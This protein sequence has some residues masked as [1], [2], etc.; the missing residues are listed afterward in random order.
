MTTAGSRSP[1][2]TPRR[3]STLE[4]ILDRAVEIMADVGVAGLTMTRLAR[5]LSIQ[6][7]SLY[8]WFP[9]VLAVHDAVFARGQRANL[10]AWRAGLEGRPA[11]LEAVVAGMTATAQWAVTHPVE[12]QLLFW[13]PVPGFRPSAAAMA[14]ADELV[15]E[16]REHLGT[17]VSRGQLAPG[18]DSADGLVV[19]ASL[20]FGVVSQHLANE[21]EAAWADGAYT[22]SYGRVTELFV[23][24][25]PPA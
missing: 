25:Y 21:P 19:L 9:S 5:A 15:A 4:A 16:L 8:K 7:P 2:R 11:G 20:H 24:A 6:P 13:R 18:A 23:A 22:R 3:E 10:A 1:R 14:P 12:A 17:A